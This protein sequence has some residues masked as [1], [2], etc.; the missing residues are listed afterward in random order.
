[1]ARILIQSIE[2]GRYF[3]APDK[4]CLPKEEA[5]DFKT[6]ADARA[7]CQEQNLRKVRLLMDFGDPRLDVPLT[8]N[9]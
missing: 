7:F 9:W 8:A 2:T 1:M 3:K 6:P 4:W 5:V